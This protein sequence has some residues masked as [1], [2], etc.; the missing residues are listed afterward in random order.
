MRPLSLRENR[1]QKMI[2]ENMRE[3]TMPQVVAEPCYAHIVDILLAN[4]KG[5][6]L[7]SEFLHHLPGDVGRTD[8]ML[9]AVVHGGGEH[10][11]HAA[12]LLQVPQALELFC[13]DDIPAIVKKLA[14]TP[15]NLLEFFQ[16]DVAMDGIHIFLGHDVMV[17]DLSA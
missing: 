14:K 7:F 6:L 17:E 4:L 10:V 5:G 2:I 13:V 12:Q 11:V 1:A 15:S 3:R 8:A 9:E 16:T